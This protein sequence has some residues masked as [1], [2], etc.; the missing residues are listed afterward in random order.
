MLSLFWAN[1]LIQLRIL[2]ASKAAGPDFHYVSVQP[3][4]SAEFAFDPTADAADFGNAFAKTRAI[5]SGSE[6]ETSE[7]FEKL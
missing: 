5:D 2:Q 3:L 1:N 7:L 4:K 6:L